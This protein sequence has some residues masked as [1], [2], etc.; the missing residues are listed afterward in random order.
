MLE[1][2]TFVAQNGQSVGGTMKNMADSEILIDGLMS[3]NMPI[4]AGFYNGLGFAKITSTI[5]NE[6]AGI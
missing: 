3:E 5:E 1:G 4:P 6:L 2:K